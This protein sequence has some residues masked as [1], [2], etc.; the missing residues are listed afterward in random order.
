MKMTEATALA[1]EGDVDEAEAV[2]E[3]AAEAA[4]DGMSEP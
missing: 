1:A 4:A 2:A 3:G